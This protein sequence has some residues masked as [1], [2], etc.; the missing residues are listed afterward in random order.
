[1]AKVIHII[2]EVIQVINNDIGE[3]LLSYCS[4]IGQSEDGTPVSSHLIVE[5]KKFSNLLCHSVGRKQEVSYR[6]KML[7]SCQHLYTVVPEMLYY[8]SFREK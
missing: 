4:E 8:L 1:M 7:D 3:V 2:E 5:V 6:G